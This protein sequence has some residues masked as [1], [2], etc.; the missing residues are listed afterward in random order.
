[1]TAA[2]KPRKAPVAHH[3]RN[4]V[5]ITNRRRRS[6]RKRQSLKLKGMHHAR[7]NMQMPIKVVE[8]A[9]YDKWVSGQK[10]LAQN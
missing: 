1:M 4:F 10:Q 8:Q 6:Q 9:E 3:I 5:W 7:F 2:K